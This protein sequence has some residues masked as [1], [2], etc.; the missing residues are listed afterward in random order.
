VGQVAV[1]VGVVGVG[2]IGA[3][4]VGRLV[5]AG[6]DVVATDVRPQRRRDVEQVGARWVPDVAEAAGHGSVLLTVLPG[7]PELRDLVAGPGK[8]LSRLP[9][10]AVWVDLTSASFELGQECAAVAQAHDVPYLDA[11]IGGG[12]PAV[13]NGVA[14]LYVGGDGAVLETA[15]PVLHAF[16]TTVHHVGGAGAGYLTKLLVNLL[17]FGHATLTT[18]V[19]LLARR[20]GQASDRM[21]ELLLDG[22]G[23]S[24]F[25]AEHL[26]AL[27]AVDYLADFGLSRC[28]EELDSVEQTAEQA[29][30]PHPVT[31]IV[32]DVYRKALAH[33]GPVDGE[34]MASAW[35]EQQAGFQ[36]SDE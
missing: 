2:R 11:P 22:A 35:L 17:W 14:T 25:I 31:S 13:R 3:P 16:A 8:L 6:H 30:V 27:L 15:L 10:G 28:V 21:R 36:L 1:P 5:A 34:L 33:F 26:P 32:A 29:G 4:L 18:E 20:H 12:V 7:V 24:A 9:S 19:L 23:S